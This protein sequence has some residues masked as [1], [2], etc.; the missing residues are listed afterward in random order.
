MSL[1]K[2]INKKIEIIKG[3]IIDQI[4]YFKLIIDKPTIDDGR[5]GDFIPN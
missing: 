5:R 1:I 4:V 3:K 2:W